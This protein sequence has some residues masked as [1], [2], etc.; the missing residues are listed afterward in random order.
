MTSKEGKPT[1]DQPTEI[2]DD[3]LD[4]AAGGL[5]LTDLKPSSL[6]PEGADNSVRK[7]G[8]RIMGVRKRG[9]RVNGVDAKGIRALG[10]RKKG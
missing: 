2:Q 8:Q 6:G 4:S 1:E 7:A 9:I 5:R 3:S 10:V